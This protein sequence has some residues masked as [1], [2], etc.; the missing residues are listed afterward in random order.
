MPVRIFFLTYTI[1]LLMMTLSDYEL[2][3]L[4][5]SMEKVAEGRKHLERV[6]S[7]SWYIEFSMVSTHKPSR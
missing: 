5:I 3:R 4:L 6:V 2:G 7:G 1:Y